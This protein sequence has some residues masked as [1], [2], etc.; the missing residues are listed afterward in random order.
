MGIGG[1]LAAIAYVTNIWD[2]LFGAAPSAP[3]YVMPVTQQSDFDFWWWRILWSLALVAVVVLIAGV[4]WS[5]F[6]RGERKTGKLTKQDRE[7][8]EQM[9]FQQK[10]ASGNPQGREL[11]SQKPIEYLSLQAAINRSKGDTWI[12]GQAIE[13]QLDKNKAHIAGE[14][15]KV[16]SNSHF[17]ILGATRSGKTKSAAFQLVLLARVNK[18]HVIVLDGKGG[19]DWRKYNG[20]V[21]WHDLTPGNLKHYVNEVT[22]LYR[23]RQQFLK[24]EDAG[25]LSE[26][27]PGKRP[28]RILVIFE[29]FGSTWVGTKRDPEIDKAMDELFRRSC[30]AGIHLCL[31]DQAPELWSRQMATNAAVALCFRAKGQ[32]LNAFGGYYCGNLKVGEFCDDTSIYKS[33]Y[34]AEEYIEGT[35]IMKL[36]PPQPRRMLAEPSN[37]SSNA[38]FEE[39]LSTNHFSN[40]SNDSLQVVQTPSNASNAQTFVKTDTPVCPPSMRRAFE[41]LKRWDEPS[42]IFFQFN[43]QATQA[44]LR[45]AMASIDGKA[46]ETYKAEA[47]KW[48]HVYSPQGDPGKLVGKFGMT[49]DSIRGVKLS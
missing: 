39:S 27:A 21:E 2:A 14:L 35:P 11:P 18:W 24:A 7:L 42:K 31:V 40:A 1:L 23:Q 4:G 16:S 29:E 33:W 46:A 34:V 28:A 3:G 8:S 43:P 19:Q 25:E 32:T 13:R 9:K 45:G 38:P 5:M 26:L 15:F 37:A 10:I 44:D 17:A 12:L 22:R 30:A 41:R 48:Y 49:E 6:V 36:L 47:F 20:A